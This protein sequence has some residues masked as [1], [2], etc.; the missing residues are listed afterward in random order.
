MDE[1]ESEIPF[2]AG[3]KAKPATLDSSVEKDGR[4]GRERGI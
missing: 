1:H 4:R 2:Q 3:A